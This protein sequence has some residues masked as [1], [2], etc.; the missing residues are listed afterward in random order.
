MY[1]WV[2]QLL[3][4][5]TKDQKENLGVTTPDYYFY[6]NQ[7]GTYTV[8]DINDQKEFSDTMVCLRSLENIFTNYFFSA[9]PMFRPL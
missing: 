7:S 8:D 5:A 2:L 1:L 4:G 6:L 9:D 3:V